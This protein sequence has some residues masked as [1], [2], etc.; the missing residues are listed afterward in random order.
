VNPQRT[1]ATHQQTKVYN[2]QLVLRTIF[3][4]S[5]TSRAEVARVTGLT[6]VTVSEIVADLLERGLVAEVGRGPSTGGKS[7]I[8]LSVVDDARH[9]I[10]VDLASYEF[11]GAVVNLRGQVRR[12]LKFPLF[13]RTGD[14]AL[15]L[16]F[17]LIDA[18][19]AATDRPILG[20]GI[21]TPGLVDTQTG[22]VRQA[23]NLEWRDLPLAALLGTRYDLPVY[24][25]NDSQ[26]AALAE[27]TFGAGRSD[28]NLVVIKAGR[29]I[30]AGTILNGH[31]FQGDH[32]AAGEIGHV[33][34]VE[35]G[36]P[37][38][39][40]KTGCLETVASSEALLREARQLAQSEAVTY[41]S[42]FAEDPNQITS[43]VI[44]QALEAG[45]PAA[46]ALVAA[47]AEALG[48]AVAFVVGILNV[49]RILLVG[50][51]TRF[52]QP[53]FEAVQHAIRCHSMPALATDVDVAVGQLD[54]NVVTLG[55]SALLLT[56]ELGLDLA[57]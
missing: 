13:G 43:D 28:H 21:G 11:R 30:G 14:D 27:H 47:A 31:L 17:D 5:A 15:A 50:T 57:R 8:L 29:G 55:A 44:G 36:Q 38:R 34:V 53:W 33:V 49:R 16:V 35:D 12:A 19:R 41:F 39:C 6:R 20:I 45:D 2:S 24:V 9:V 10:G 46:L 48:R 54:E 18:L 7:P 1:K 25:A 51:L 32:S 4:H 42:Q 40:G 3:D 22:V 52:G 23:V 37:C 56:N 26:V